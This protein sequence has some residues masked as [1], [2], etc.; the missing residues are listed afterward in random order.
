MINNYKTELMY[1][2]VFEKYAFGIKWEQKFLSKEHP[3]L[4][5]DQCWHVD[6]EIT[7]EIYD[8]ETNAS[9]YPGRRNEIIRWGDDWMDADWQKA[10]YS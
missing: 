10:F 5:A 7:W 2:R 9:C 4:E 3:P 6:Y 1:A 8:K